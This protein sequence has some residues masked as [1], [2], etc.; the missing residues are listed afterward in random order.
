M[1]VEPGRSGRVC[2]VIDFGHWA[3]HRIL[4][5]SESGTCTP[6]DPRWGGGVERYMVCSLVLVLVLVL[7]FLR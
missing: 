3:L 5:F 2:R 4:H 6:V 1:K 7:G